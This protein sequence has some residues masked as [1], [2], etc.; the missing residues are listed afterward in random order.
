MRLGVNHQPAD[1]SQNN[2][3]SEDV[4]RRRTQ[5][6][7]QR[8]SDAS[9]KITSPVNP[10]P[11]IVRGHA[12][13]GLP[14]NNAPKKG[15]GRK[16]PIVNTPLYNKNGNR[17]RRQFYLTMD[18]YPG[19]ELRLPA[20]PII[21]P[22]W[23]FLSG[24][25]AIAMLVGIYSLLNSSYFQVNTVEVQGL[26][27]ITA[28]EVN[29]VVKL[30]DE[31]VISVDGGAVREELVNKY[32]ELINVQVKVSLPN[33]VTLSAV[34]RTPVMAV[35]KGDSVTWIDADGVLFPQRGDAGKLLTIRT[36]D[37]LPLAPTS[38]DAAAAATE[39]AQ[40]GAEMNQPTAD[41]AASKNIPA[42]GPQ[43]VDPALITTAE[44]LSKKLPADAT[45]VYS[46]L[47]GLGWTDA[48]GTQVFIGKDTSDFEAKFG[49]YQEIDKFLSDQGHKATLIDVE[50]V[51]APFYRLEQHNNGG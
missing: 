3:R 47:N 16:P 45:L 24:I 23:R 10:R 4:R 15:A 32:P 34:E 11:V 51:N 29:D 42:T 28:Q 7:Q 43:K 35:Q 40:Q 33:Y 1:G 31:S 27:R 30:K 48:Q 38:I 21:N 39:T 12:P 22:G 20:L 2:N 6:S 9:H 50:H 25:I 17:S 18:Q 46:K 14:W 37:A 5:R 44:N 19:T 41:P 8:I 49:V 13:Q 36:D 26:H